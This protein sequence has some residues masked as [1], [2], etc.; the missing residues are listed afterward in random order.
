MRKR[1]KMRR[2]L[3]PG[4]IAAI[5]AVGTR[6]RLAVLVGIH[7]SS[8]LKWRRIPTGRIV[9]VEKLTGVDR[10]VLRPDLYKREAA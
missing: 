2:R 7:P 9:Q 6:Y 3:D 1:R 5:K 10:T 4:L 8:V